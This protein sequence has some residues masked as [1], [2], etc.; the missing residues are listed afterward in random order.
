ME[1]YLRALAGGGLIGIA[2]VLM[3]LFNGKILGISGIAGGILQ[4]T[5]EKKHWRYLFF[6]GLLTGGLVVLATVPGAFDVSI[7]RSPWALVAAGLLV[8]YG[9]RL[10]NGCTSGHGVCG[11]SRL[12]PRSLM[13]TL[14][15][16]AFGAITVFAINH[17]LGGRL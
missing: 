11:V 13:A 9:T 5:R 1:G 16:M 14:T 17:L 8:G 3:L 6:L 12:S 4:K 10:G 2:S 15:F 7:S